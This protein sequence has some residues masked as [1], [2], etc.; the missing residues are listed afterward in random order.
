MS[1]ASRGAIRAAISVGLLT[2]PIARSMAARLRLGA[3][4]A[5]AGLLIPTAG[6]IRLANA[7]VDCEV[8]P[9]GSARTDCYIGLSRV[10]QQKSEIAAGIAREQTD[11]AI[12]RQLT[13]QRPKPRW[14][15]PLPDE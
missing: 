11:R 3:L 1:T 9:A 2:M 7:Q 5:G 14:H 8:L 6:P 10:Q 4:L 12:Y 13:G 15:R